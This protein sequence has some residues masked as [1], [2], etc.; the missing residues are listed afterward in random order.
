M[1]NDWPNKITG[2]N[3]GGPRQFSIPPPL[4]GRG[5]F[6]AALQGDW[7]AP[8]QHG[9]RVMSEGGMEHPARWRSEEE[10][11]IAAPGW[12]QCPDAHCRGGTPA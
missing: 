3:A 9:P 7:E 1:R 12:R 2:P 10:P 6:S 5:P 8:A 4:A 11:F